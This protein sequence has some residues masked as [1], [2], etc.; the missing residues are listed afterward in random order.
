MARIFGAALGQAGVTVREADGPRSVNSATLGE[1]GYFGILERGPVNK[2]ISCYSRTDFERQ[3]GGII[4][5]SHVPQIMFDYFANGGTGAHLVRITDGSEVEAVLDLY[6]RST[7]RN[8]VARMTAKNG[9]RWAGRQKVLFGTMPNGAGTDLSETTL[10]TE[11]TMLKDEWKGATLTLSGVAGKTYTVLSNTTAGVLT[12]Q[13]DMTMSTDYGAATDEGWSL[14]LGH[15]SEKALTIR[16][17]NGEVSPNTDWSMDVYLNGQ[18]Y[19]RWPNLSMDPESKFYFVRL[20]NDDGRNDVVEAEDLNAPNSVTASKRPANGWGTSSAVTARTL[21][22]I[23]FQY[24]TTVGDTD[25]TIALGALT[26]AMQYAENLRIVFTSAT[27]FDVY[28][29]ILGNP[30]GAATGVKLNPSALTV[31]TAVDPTSDFDSNWKM[32]PPFTITDGGSESPEAADE[33][34]LEYRPLRPNGLKDGLITPDIVNAS[35]EAFRIL[36]NTVSVITIVSGD[37]T[38]NATA[39]DKFYVTYPEIMT[40]GYDG[41]ADIDDTDYTQQ[42]DYLTT[43]LKSLKDENKGLIKL[44]VPGITS[45]VVQQSCAALAELMDWQFRCEVPVANVT[46]QQA[47]D[48]IINTLGLNDFMVGAFPSYGYVPD[49]LRSG[50]LKLSPLTGKIHGV[51]ARIARDNRGY[52]KVAGGVDGILTGV[53]KLPTV[54]DLNDAVLN[55]IGLQTIRRKRF[56]YT[57]WGGRTLAAD[58]QWK[59][60]PHREAMSYYGNQI[61]SGFDFAVFRLNNQETRNIV[62][63]SLIAMF[64]QFYQNG[65]FDGNTFED[66]VQIDLS[67]EANTLLSIAAG[68]LHARVTVRLVG[69]VERVQVTIGQKGILEEIV[70]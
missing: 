56:G 46:E 54:D 50:A 11:L 35:S 61:L 17:G 20:I 62:R 60:K 64:L 12:V 8:K 39:G 22:V 36:S 30:T 1:V 49:P 43:P 14:V 15:D 24:T 16:V 4:S 55:G 2:R 51:E 29:L 6:D 37:M 70:A 19:L 59:F 10:D 23:P 52:H 18:S 5:E 66:A 7:P 57:I 48:Y 31:G 44:A 9:G 68:E 40:G 38:V 26:S 47:V 41:I 27:E 63:T 53:N 42:M 58:P 45:S 33:I 3:C 67:A 32:I 34:L 25:V 65:A 69:M 21:T 28:S 13:P